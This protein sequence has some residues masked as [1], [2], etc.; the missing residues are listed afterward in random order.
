MQV[1]TEPVSCK[2]AR[3]YSRDPDNVTYTNAF[4]EAYVAKKP[5]KIKRFKPEDFGI[6]W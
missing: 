2:N 5:K 4:L 6:K 3:I 1:V